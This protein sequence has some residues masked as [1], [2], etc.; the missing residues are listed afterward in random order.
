M[1]LCDKLEKE[2]NENKIHSEQLMQ[3]VLRE[4]FEENSN[5]LHLNNKYLKI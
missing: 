2:I 5:K 1:S 4:A 3:Y